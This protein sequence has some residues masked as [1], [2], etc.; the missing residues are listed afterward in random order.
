M[1]Q[2]AKNYTFYYIDEE[3]LK[4]VRN[5]R[6]HPSP[7]ELMSPGS[8]ELTLSG[9]PSTQRGTP[10]THR[11]SPFAQGSSPFTQLSSPF[12]QL[13]SPFSQGSSPGQ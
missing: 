12:T 9:T 3:Y 6:P 8:R 5:F 7:P 4:E 10:S 13:S 1:D 2:V 11:S